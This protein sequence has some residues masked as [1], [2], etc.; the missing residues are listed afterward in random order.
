MK[1]TRLGDLQA[2]AAGGDD[3][4]GGGDGPAVLLCHGY[5][6]PGD[7]L[8]SLHR[9]IDAGPG[10]RWFFPAAPLEVEG[11]FGG[12]AWWPIDMMAL[13][14]AM[15]RGLSRDLAAR[16]P[17]GLPEAA[18]ALRG[19]I[20]ALARDHGVRRDR[21]VIGGFSQGAMLTTEVALGAD[22]PFA[23]LAV[24]SGTLLHRERWQAAADARAKGLSVV[25]SHGRRDPILPFSGAEALRDV[26]TGAG[27][28][29]TFVPFHGAHEI[30]YPVIDA[31]GA[32]ARAR[33]A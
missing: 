25:Q 1:L 8:V 15:A 32:F 28:A 9:V 30:P 11:G 18:E 2:I 29:V 5:G 7:D 22:E 31:V 6:A 3:R 12:R 23:G 4:E 17:D 10:V 21:L 14:L 20:A 24:L 16:T 26:L 27:A 19:A 33:L 13:Q